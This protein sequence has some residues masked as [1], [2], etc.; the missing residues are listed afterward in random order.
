M[1]IYFSF[2]Q[3]FTVYHL[4]VSFVKKFRI[5]NF[6]MQVVVRTNYEWE[7]AVFT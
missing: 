3:K 2:I 1:C 4:Q 7:D 5:K 6:R